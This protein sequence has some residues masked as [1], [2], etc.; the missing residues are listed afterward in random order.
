MENPDAV[1]FQLIGETGFERLTAGFYGAWRAM[2]FFG[3]C[4]HPAT[5]RPRGDGCETF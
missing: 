5:S 1:V 4:I 3:R 2:I